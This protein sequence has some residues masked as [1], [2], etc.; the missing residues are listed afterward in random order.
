MEE[1]TGPASLRDTIRMVIGRVRDLRSQ[2][3][4][5]TD[6]PRPRRMSGRLV[7]GLATLLICVLAGYMIGTSAALAKG[8]D[9]R[10]G[11]TTDLI[12]MVT[13]ESQRNAAL[14]AQVSDVR[15]QV[16]RLSG[17]T[18]ASGVSAQQLEQAATNAQTTPVSGPGLTVVLNDA[19]S[20]VAPPDVDP[21]LLVVHQQDIQ[22][23]VNALWQGGAE[24]MTIQGQRVISTTGIKCVGNTV[25]L[26]GIP[27]APPYRIQVIG[28]QNALEAALLSSPYVSNYQDYVAAYGLGYQERREDNLS[29]PAYSGGIE[30][31]YARP[32][33]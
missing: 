30:L 17:A 29:F 1:P 16:D 26:Q 2:R 11:R 33:R 25:V 18:G 27:Y 7:A 28:D 31:Q 9:L 14:A 5:Q 24:A 12:S 21:D 23:V 6:V 20:S 13:V 3:S 8:T 32:A 22:A 15:A 10:G 19:P 4:A